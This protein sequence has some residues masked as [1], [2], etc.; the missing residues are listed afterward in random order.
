MTARPSRSPGL[1]AL[2]L[3][4]AVLIIA[5]A[6]V[7]LASAGVGLQTL[8]EGGRRAVT[9]ASDDLDHARQLE[10]HVELLARHVRQARILEDA[11]LWQVV[12]ED[13]RTVSDEAA[14]VHGSLEGARAVFSGVDDLRSR[15]Q[16]VLG[17]PSPA[18]TEAEILALEQAADRAVRQAD[19]A[20]DHAVHALARDARDFRRTM[21][22]QIALVL[23][24]TAIVLLLAQRWVVRPLRQ[25]GDAISRL[26]EG[27]VED[28]VRVGGPADL[29]RLGGR[30]EWLRHRLVDEESQRTRLLQHV[31][32]E[33]KT[34]LTAVR[35]GAELLYEGTLDPEDARQVAGILRSNA[36]KLSRRIGD[37]LRLS[38]LA[39]GEVELDAEVV[40]LADLA[41]DVIAQHALVARSAQVQVQEDLAPTP[42]LG[43]RH[44]LVTV[45]DNLVTNALKVSPPG[46]RVRIRTASNPTVS[47]LTVQDDGPGFRPQDRDRV[48]EP[49][50]RGPSGPLARVGGTGLGLTIAREYARAH[51]GEL[52]IAD[53]DRGALLELRLPPF[54]EADRAS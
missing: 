35:E 40:D 39:R 8:A 30:L 37:L 10:S 11:A 27:R 17:A 33:L 20:V 54:P 36:D 9:R 25:V 23:P 53:V 14:Q 42:V 22:F 34:P 1:Q 48:F 47:T 3:L 18:P 19:E 2:I 46:G 51:R 41:R 15:P 13:V 4:A 21:F 26:G 43:D 44:R 28:P 45:I 6:A 38:E 24:L 31:S 32:H 49:F 12:A 16:G 29:R 7:A 50:F 52:T 5:P